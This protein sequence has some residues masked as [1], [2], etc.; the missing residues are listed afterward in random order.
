MASVAENVFD[1]VE[2]EI[3]RLDADEFNKPDI[4][5]DITT[6][7]PKE[8]HSQ[9]DIVYMSHVL[10]HIER[11]KII[12]TVRYTISAVKN[13]GEVWIIVPSMEWAASEIIH[14][15]DG[16]HVQ[17]MLY[18]AQ[19]NPFD[20][21]RVG[22]TLKGLRSVMEICGLITRKAYQSPFQIQMDDV[23]MNC[24]QNV[25]IGTRFDALIEAQKAGT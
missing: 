3:T 17:G 16:A 9:F 1:N 15:R 8:L 10:E 2:K 6:P 24:V 11:Q 21:H 23:L 19:H 12:N 18:G 7:L 20:Y 25:V 14:G 13:L 4:L 22:F 5:H